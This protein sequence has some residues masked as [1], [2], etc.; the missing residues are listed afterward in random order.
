MENTTPNNGKNDD[1]QG[2]LGDLEEL[3]SFDKEILNPESYVA[4]SIFRQ[5]DSVML[6][7]IVRMCHL[8]Y[9]SREIAKYIY[10]NNLEI[11]ARY[12]EMQTESRFSDGTPQA[13]AKAVRGFR[14][15][16]MAIKSRFP[17]FPVDIYL[18][19]VITPM[20]DGLREI[21]VLIALQKERISDGH[22]TEK[23][24]GIN[25]KQVSNDIMVLRQL[26]IDYVRLCEIFGIE[27]KTEYQTPAENY[28]EIR[29]SEEYCKLSEELAKLGDEEVQ[30]MV[31]E[32]MT[33]T[34]SLRR[35]PV[36]RYD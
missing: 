36:Q 17:Q 21:Q 29:N 4:H 5:C 16:T 35:R 26:I 6:A 19:R 9:S 11:K 7:E 34:Y 23:R 22:G 20:I 24:I 30:K 15:K 12:D 13:L 25:N 32:K 8:M 33:K 31:L 28:D 3:P 14:E 18:N 10:E 1:F 2:F 27:P